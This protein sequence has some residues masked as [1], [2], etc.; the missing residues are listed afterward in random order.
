M[1]NIKITNVVILDNYII[2]NK[3][4]EISDKKE[5]LWN[6]YYMRIVI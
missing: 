5:N 6:I 3:A 4:N 2:L 1:K